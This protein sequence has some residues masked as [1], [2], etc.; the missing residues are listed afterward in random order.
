MRATLTPHS[1]L[2]GGLP[3]CRIRLGHG[4]AAGVGIYGNTYKWDD[5]GRDAC[6]RTYMTVNKEFCYG[7][8]GKIPA[9][10]PNAPNA[11]NPPAVKQG[12]KWLKARSRTSMD[13]Q[14]KPSRE[15][16][17]ERYTS[18]SKHYQGGHRFLNGQTNQQVLALAN[19]DKVVNT[20]AARSMDTSGRNFYTSKVAGRQ[21]GEPHPLYGDGPGIVFQP[22]GTGKRCLKVRDQSKKSI[23]SY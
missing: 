17:R 23:H 4:A 21:F 6:K 22:F 14:L 3:G 11:P 1:A 19:Q 12:L 2:R 20:A 10:A 8:T 5:I 18:M 9:E 7:N 15:L 16:V 13:M